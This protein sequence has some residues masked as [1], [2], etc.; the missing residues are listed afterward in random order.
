[1]IKT[2][3]IEMPKIIEWLKSNKLHI[4]VD[5]TVAMLFQTRQKHVNI[6]ENSIVNDGN[7]IPFA[8]NTRFLGINIDNDLTWK[9]LIN[10]IAT[11]ISKG[12]VYYYVLVQNYH[13][14]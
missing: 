2:I 13:I 9:A 3:N 5:K 12:E 6:Y 14:S 8:T 1:M 4:N 11:K 10:Y 7:I